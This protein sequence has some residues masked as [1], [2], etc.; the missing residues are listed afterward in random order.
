[1]SDPATPRIPVVILISGRGSNL[2]AIIEAV[3]QNELPIDIRAV[4]SNRPAAGGLRAK[5]PCCRKLHTC[6]A[7]SRDS[8]IVEWLE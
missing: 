2:H 5:Q 1:M 3:R 7:T 4:I 8:S 6:T